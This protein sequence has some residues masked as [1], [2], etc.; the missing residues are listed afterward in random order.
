MLGLNHLAEQ[1]LDLARTFLDR[2]DADP[3][4]ETT[5]LL[6]VLSRIQHSAGGLL[7]NDLLEAHFAQSRTVSLPLAGEVN[8]WA[9]QSTPFT[10]GDD[11]TARIEE[12]VR[13]TEEFMGVPFPVTDVILVLPSVGG[14]R[15]HGFR[16]GGI[17]WFGDF[18]TITRRVP[19][20]VNLGL[21]YHEVAH[22]YFT[23]RIGPQWLVEGGANFLELYTLERIGRL[24]IA[25]A[26]SSVWQR[27][28][29]RC[30]SDG[31]GTI[32]ELNQRTNSDGYSPHNCA[33]TL[34]AYFLIRL[35]ETIGKEGLSAALRELHLRAHEEPRPENE[36][37]LARYEQEIY[38]ILLKHTPTEKQDAFHEVYR[39]IHGGPH[40]DDT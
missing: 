38:R 35:Y 8:L 24:S 14:E 36:E 39:E 12:A 40:A 22:Y 27:V 26:G 9:F 16:T 18:I 11:L 37:D 20:P 1:D 10:R 5:A 31:I 33:Y 4:G 3:S 29:K 32:Q 13:A 15:D 19:H 17:N 34:G 30:L 25:T 21:L 7:Y 28:E 6:T 2:V 23:G